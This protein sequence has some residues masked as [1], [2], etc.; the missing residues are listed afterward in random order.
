MGKKIAAYPGSFDP[1]TYGHVNIV[2]RTAERFN[3]LYVI[4][5]NNPNKEYLFSLSERLEMVKTDLKGI[6]NVVVD[7][8]DGLLVDYLK[9]HRI[10]NLIRG[11]RAVSDFEYELQMANANR[12]LFPELEIF[13]LMADT[14]FS[15]ISS[16]MI[17][18]IANYEGDISKWVS[19]N[20]EIKLKEKLSK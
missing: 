10:F 4:V 3:K 15:F 17:K 1:I 13:F 6:K 14:D 16:S 18:E 8:F 19:K 9:R 2:K 7:T 12:S 5:M 11:L 20:V